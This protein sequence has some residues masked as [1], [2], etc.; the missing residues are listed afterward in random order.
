MRNRWDDPKGIR[1]SGL[2]RGTFINTMR[3]YLLNNLDAFIF[4]YCI[5]AS[6]AV[7]IMLF[8]FISGDMEA[9]LLH[10][11]D[12]IL[13]YGR[14]ASW[15]YEIGNYPPLYIYFMTVATLLP[16]EPIYSIKIM[17]CIFDYVSAYYVY[18]IVKSV[19]KNSTN[20]PRCAFVATVFMPTVVVNSSLW[21]Q[22]DSMYSACILA[23]V[24]YIISGKSVLSIVAFSI[25]ISLKP[26][27][28]F[29]TPF[30]FA[31]Y[32]M[33]MYR[34]YAIAIVPLLYVL[35]TV[36]AVLMGRSLYDL[37]L[38]YVNQPILPGPALTLGAPN[39]YQWLSD[40]EH[41]FEILFNAGIVLSFFIG[42][43]YSMSITKMHN[44]R[45]SKKDL[46]QTS[47]LCILLMPFVLP[48]MHERY[49]YSADVLAV[50]YAFIYPNRCRVVLMIQCAS[51]F[52][53]LPYLFGKE[54]IP[55]M[56]LSFLILLGIAC[57]TR[58][59]IDDKLR[60]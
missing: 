29:I 27:A 50:A 47:L 19:Y 25:A 31:C 42:L 51:F 12:D 32:L 45:Y 33:G 24:F 17:H 43:I 15:G 41:H 3:R 26:Q 52:C 14:V 22:C 23:C 10:W 58:Y 5:L 54:P 16:I 7:R 60:E 1:K 8:D 38:L 53:Y 30:L 39:M 46:I 28:V 56:Y 21:G 57:I 37:L 34:T 9:F 2:T 49:F 6:V 4:S 48:A 35:F 20:L 59:I 55:V 18:L 36:P 11:Y 13:N 40:K 44:D